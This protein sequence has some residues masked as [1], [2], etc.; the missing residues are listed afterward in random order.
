MSHKIA[1][2][3]LTCIV[4]TAL[5]KPHIDWHLNPEF[6]DTLDLLSERDV[7]R[8]R[9]QRRLIG[10]VYQTSN[11]IQYEAAID[12]VLARSTAKL[13]TLK[14]TQ[15]ELNEWMHI[16][17]VECLSAAVLSWSPGMLKNG[18]DNGSGTH[19]YHGWR[20]KSVF[21]LFP[22]VAKLEFLH[23]SIGRLFSTIWGVNFQP[24][25]DFRPFFPV[26]LP[27]RYW[28]MLQC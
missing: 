11:L 4:A 9:I 8:Y 21:G 10:P 6:Q 13:K 27:C 12:E 2:W 25:K 15:V 5:S 14:G 18:T 19:A 24:P 23:K 26:R 28:K 3:E 17:A 7:R 22:T 1:E 20:R 16:I